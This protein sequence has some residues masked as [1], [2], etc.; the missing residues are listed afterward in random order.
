MHTLCKRV[1]LIGVVVCSLLAVRPLSAQTFTSITPSAFA[2]I[3]REAGYAPEV[4]DPSKAGEAQTVRFKVEGNTSLVLFFD[5]KEG[6][7]SNIQYYAGW[8]GRSKNRDVVINRWNQ[9][10]RFGRAYSDRDGDPVLEMDVDFEGGVHYE[11]I[12]ASMDTWRAII[13]SFR[14]DVIDN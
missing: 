6:T 4:L 11:N 13:G 3:L 12:V 8:N 2:S 5:C 1:L 14:A 7:C 9:S 10:H